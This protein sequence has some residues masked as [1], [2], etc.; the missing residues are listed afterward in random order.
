MSY[1][2]RIG[3][4]AAVCI[5]V[6]V[7]GYKFMKGKNL[8]NPSNY[9]YAVYDDIDELAPTSPVLIRGMRIGTVS[10]VS[11]S[12]DMQKI[13]ATLDIN[14][15]IRIP[16]NTE[17]LVVNVS[18]MGGKSVVLDVPTP[19]DGD[20]CAQH[21][22]TLVGRVQGMF[23]SMISPDDIAGAKTKLG[24]ILKDLSDSLSS[25]GSSNEFAKTFQALQHVLI[26]LE[27][28]TKQLN[29]SMSAYD[30]RTQSVL[31]NVES[32]TG[33]LAASNAQI[34]SAISNLDAVSAD[35][36]S[37]NIGK[38]TSET[39]SSAQEA[40]KELD[41]AISGADKSFKQ[42]DKLLTDIN[43][44]QGSLGLLV[45]DKKL[46]NN[47]TESSRQLNLLLQDFRLNPKRYVNVSV[48][49]KKQKEYDIPEEDPAQKDE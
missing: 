10:K 47:L 13:V 43:S 32:I 3:L 8:L 15:G 21:G 40:I 22:D 20:D 45:K 23:E 33:N 29:A 2:L 28:I 41:A 34:S 27:G 30:R 9:Y 26:N 12:A 48:F 24:G 35:L 1:E 5:A 39:M 19:C 49:G 36:K 17:A 7:W 38:A 46:Y 4:L 6:T 11:L 42:L 16:K 37:A 44:G 18:I 25:P 31:K 14:K